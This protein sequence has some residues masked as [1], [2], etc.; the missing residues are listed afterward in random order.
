ME[1][2]STWHIVTWNIRGNHSPAPRDIASALSSLA[3][4]GQIDVI[5]LQEVRRLQARSIARRLGMRHVW[6]FKHNG[7]TALLPLHAEGHAVLTP[8]T[9]VG[10]AH[11][12][13][14]AGE[15]R[16]S[17]RRRIALWADI[18][19]AG[20]TL[21]VIDTHLASH[22]EPVARLEQAARVRSLVDSSPAPSVIAGDFN[23][24]DEPAVVATI[25]RSTHVDAWSHAISRS[26][27]GLTNPSEAPHQRLDHLLVPGD[28][29]VRVVHT[30]SPDARWTP[31]SDHLPVA[32]TCQMRSK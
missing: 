1:T 28:W 11:E 4:D 15:Q 12:T 25:A 9:I 24:K 32:V 17:Y 23:D 22:D 13:I 5:A 30:P 16:R 31:L 8:H 6:A 19:R 14:S 2:S 3:A 27:N 7:Y 21:R 20:S 26:T 10:H 29:T 18:D